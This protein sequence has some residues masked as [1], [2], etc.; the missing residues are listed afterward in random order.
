[1]YAV[2]AEHAAVRRA[3]G[4]DNRKVSVSWLQNEP[5]LFDMRVSLIVHKDIYGVSDF[6]LC[7]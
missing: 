2:L 5:C 4:G 6:V 3:A 7:G 1:M